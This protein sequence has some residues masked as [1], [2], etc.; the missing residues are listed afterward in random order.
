MLKIS[1]LR[2]KDV[3][4]VKDGKR[5]GYIDD[6]ELDVESGRI[7]ALIVPVEERRIFGF[8]NRG[9]ETVV[10]WRQIHKIGTDVILVDPER[11][12]KEK[13]APVAQEE[14]KEAG[15]PESDPIQE[16]YDVEIYQE[17]EDLFRL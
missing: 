7:T 17:P 15:E 12:S 8:L 5:L 11:L 2:S 16:A 6:I 3:I 1:E 14:P 9:D 10:E 4:N 13:P